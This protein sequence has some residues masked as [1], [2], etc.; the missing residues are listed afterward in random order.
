MVGPARGFGFDIEKQLV[1]GLM[2]YATFGG[3]MGM[4]WLFCLHCCEA[5]VLVGGLAAL[6]LV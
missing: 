5:E 6:E 2:G 3:G 1:L 4:R